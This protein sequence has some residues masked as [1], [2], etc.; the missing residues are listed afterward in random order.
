[1]LSY[2]DSVTVSVMPYVPEN[3]V[4][5]SIQVNDLARNIS[6]T[7][8]KSTSYPSGYWQNNMAPSGMTNAPAGQGPMV[9]PGNY[10]QIAVS[11]QNMGTISGNLTFTIANSST[12]AVLNTQTIAV[13]VAPAQ[14]TTTYVTLSM[15]SAP[16]GL[17]VSVTP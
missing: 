10:L 17:L 5:T 11:A 2:A 14:A 4:L 15:P 3:A 16:L 6:Y 13:A 8:I 7:W 9:T 1:M 12:S